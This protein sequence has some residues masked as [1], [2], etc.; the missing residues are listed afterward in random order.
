MDS[1]SAPPPKASSGLALVPYRGR[2]D[3]SMGAEMRKSERGGTV[4]SCS[5]EFKC[6]GSSCYARFACRSLLTLVWV[7]FDTSVGLF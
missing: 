3:N 5:K 2:V 6:R 4:S 1:R 7:S